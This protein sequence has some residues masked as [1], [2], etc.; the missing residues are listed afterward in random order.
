MEAHPLAV[1]RFEGMLTDSITKKPLK[2]IVSIIDLTT[3]IEV[4]SKYIR[5]DGSFA[6]DLIDNSRYMMII[7]GEDFFRIEELFFMDGDTE[8][9]RETDPIESKIAFSS[10][11]FENGKADIL[12]AGDGQRANQRPLAN[13]SRYGFAY[14][15]PCSRCSI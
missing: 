8:M 15:S 6:F 5:D 10:L 13:T 4:A 3:G 14:C 7:Q 11:E 9:H 2:G 12:P 1:T